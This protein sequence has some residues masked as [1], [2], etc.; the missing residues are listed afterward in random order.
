MSSAAPKKELAVEDLTVTISEEIHVK[1][2]LEDTFAAL[3]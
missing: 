2:G 1:A 3:L